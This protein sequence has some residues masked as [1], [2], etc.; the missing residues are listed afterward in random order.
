MTASS[1]KTAHTD[2]R[3]LMRDAQELFRQATAATGGT[4]DELRSKG[5]DL[6]DIALNHGQEIQA[7]AL[8]TGKEISQATDTYVRQNPWQAIAVSAG[9][10]LL[11]GML[12]ARK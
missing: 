3:S 4:A 10:G 2:M 8:E 1:Y 11:V 9:V 6:L 12:L 5:L 7:A